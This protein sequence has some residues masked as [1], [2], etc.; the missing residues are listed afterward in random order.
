MRDFFIAGCDSIA[1]RKIRAVEQAGKYIM[2]TQV[3]LRD[4]RKITCLVYHNSFYG[5]AVGLSCDWYNAPQ[6]IVART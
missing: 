2:E 5:G 6:S 3:V 4:G 1:E